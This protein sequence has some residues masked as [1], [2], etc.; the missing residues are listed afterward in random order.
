MTV[1]CVILVGLTNVAKT[2]CS[3]PGTASD[4]AVKSADF[5]LPELETADGHD[6]SGRPPLPA[7]FVD[8]WPKLPVHVRES[9]TTLIDAAQRQAAAGK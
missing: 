8:A 3:G 4:S 6:C 1:W 5:T 7:Y 9:I 2:G